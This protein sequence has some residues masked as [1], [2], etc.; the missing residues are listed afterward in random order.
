MSPPE[1]P[2]WAR[3]AA[4]LLFVVTSWW[5]LHT[6]AIRGVAG[7]AVAPLSLGVVAV[8]ILR[9][10]HQRL[11]V[12][13]W[14]HPRRRFSVRWAVA[15]PTVFALVVVAAGATPA[16]AEIARALLTGDPGLLVLVVLGGVAWSLSVGLVRQTPFAPWYGIAV[17]AALVPALV[18]LGAGGGVTAPT[19]GGAA[20]GAASLG[21]PGLAFWS[22][23]HI[24]RVLVGEE[25][26]FR[27]LLV[28]HPERAGLAVV[29]GAAVVSGLWVSVT[30]GGLA[31]ADPRTLNAVSIGLVSGLLYVLSGSLLVTSL[32]HGLYLGVLTAFGGAGEAASWYAPPVAPWTVAASAVVAAALGVVVARR[33]GWL[34]GL[35]ALPDEAQAHAPGD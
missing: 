13:P 12:W 16:V 5:L 15:V 9:G 11:G 30:H 28:G 3:G 32:Y 8:F 29:A 23:M 1:L 6:E 7:D 33:R 18:G 14:W 22:V 24:A 10:M 20:G 4:S 34:R 17:G 21:V 26:A 27:R 35:R 25:L 19:A 31:I 2:V